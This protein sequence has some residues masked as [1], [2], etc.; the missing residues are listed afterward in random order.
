M[1]FCS[2]ITSIF[3]KN[4]L[5]IASLFHF[6]A[7]LT[8]ILSSPHRLIAAS[9]DKPVQ[10]YSRGVNTVVGTL[11][12]KNTG[13]LYYMA[14]MQMVFFFTVGIIIVMMHTA[15]RLQCIRKPTYN[16]CET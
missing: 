13:T 12:G 16:K 9:S 3:Y 8:S 11:N 15:S 7:K 4:M 1:P 14:E 2:Q 10:E 6:F 5:G